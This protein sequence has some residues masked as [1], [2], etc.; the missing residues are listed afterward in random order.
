MSRIFAS[1]YGIL[2]F[3]ALALGLLVAAVF[4]LAIIIGQEPG[5]VMALRSEEFMTWGIALAAVATAAGLV[6]VYATRSHS[7]KME[8]PQKDQTN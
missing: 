7:L 1:I 3:I 8:K 6:W 5:T 4:T 2:T